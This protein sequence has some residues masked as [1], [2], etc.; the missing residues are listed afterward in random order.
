METY[1]TLAWW[2]KTRAYPAKDL[3][4]AWKDILFSEFHDLVTG[5]G[6]E[7]SSRTATPCWA[8]RRKYPKAARRAPDFPA[9]DEPLAERNA[10][11]IFVFNPHP[12]EVTQEV[13]I[14]FGI[15][16]QCSQTESSGDS[17]RMGRNPGPVRKA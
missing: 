11:P 7:K 9:Q 17:S 3:E 10:T 2:N 8:M 14:D 13:E 1:A 12:W 6:T 16:Y 4:V 5:S 15:D